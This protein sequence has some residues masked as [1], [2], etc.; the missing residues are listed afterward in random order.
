MRVD[1]AAW[2]P[3]S[4]VYPAGQGSES[5]RF[6]WGQLPNRRREGEGSKE[7][8]TGLCST[9][10]RLEEIS[11]N[12]PRPLIRDWQVPEPA[13]KDS[14]T[15]SRSCERMRR[16]YSHKRPCWFS[17][18][19]TPRPW[20]GNGL[21]FARLAGNTGLRPRVFVFFSTGS[22]QTKWLWK[23]GLGRWEGSRVPVFSDVW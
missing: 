12:P 20:L 22:E 9:V 13:R 10:Q 18:A 14:V 6:P 19:P 3:P 21:G 15:G 17:S 16:N 1:S 2:T 5:R 11:L 4:N 7:K 23:G 8:S